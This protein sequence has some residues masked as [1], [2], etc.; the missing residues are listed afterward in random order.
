MEELKN[1]KTIN[2]FEIVDVR[3]L[4]R[5]QDFF[6]KTMNISLQ[7]FYKTKPITH[8]SN[9]IPFC[10]D[11][12]QNSSLGEKY[13]A[14]CLN[15]WLKVVEKKKEP[16]IFKCHA[17]LEN[18]A[19]PI[20]V[21]DDYAGSIIGGRIL[22]VPPDENQFKKI[23]KELKINEDKYFEEAGNLRIIPSE[24]FKTIVESLDLLTNSFVAIIYAN[25][26]LSKLG[27]NYKVTKDI[28]VEDWLLLKGENNDIKTPIT[29]RELE[30]LRLIVSGKSNTE[31]AKDLFISVHTVKAHVS[32][33]L[34]KFLVDDRVQ[35]AVKAVKEGLV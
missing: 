35:V 28:E 33:I 12:M 31:I 34:D 3:F 7:C 24:K 25:F 21:N 13:C 20:I 11:V 15:Q 18:F 4:Q 1:I 26:L 6:A 23:A 27:M 22:T 9:F 19:I 16:I 8:I 2:I 29:D 17:N 14:D 5:T 10:S 32:S 30:V